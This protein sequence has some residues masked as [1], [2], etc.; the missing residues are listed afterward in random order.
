M[1]NVFEEI[2][3]A[4]PMEILNSLKREVLKREYLADIN[5]APLKLYD[6]IPERV[7]HDGN[8]K[9]AMSSISGAGRGIFVTQDIAAGTVLFKVPNV[10]LAAVNTGEVALKNTCDYCFTTVHSSGFNTVSMEPVSFRACK[11]CDVLHYCNK[12]SPTSRLTLS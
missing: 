10:L 11:G 12:V 7:I 2:V 5:E 4:V 1:A 6:T 8:I 3:E 9:V